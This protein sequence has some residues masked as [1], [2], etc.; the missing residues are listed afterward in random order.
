MAI[1][2]GTAIVGMA[3]LL[4]AISGSAAGPTL[5]GATELAL[6]AAHTSNVVRRE[7]DIHFGKQCG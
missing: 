2:C 5:A 6:T 4:T 7:I 3:V 1:G